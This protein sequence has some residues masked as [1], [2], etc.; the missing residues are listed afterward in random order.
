M[1]KILLLLILFATT[2]FPVFANSKI[3]VIKVYDG[4]SILAQINDNIFRIRLINI[5]CFE[6][7]AS[8]RAK[9][10]AKKYKLSLEEIVQGGN[11]AGQILKEK[12]KN[13]EVFFEFKGIDK[14]NRALG[15]LYVDNKNINS[16]MLK[17]S[18][19]KTFK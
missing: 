18:Y 12:L 15:I 7:T 10:Q 17:T 9:W 4:D 11:T 14:Y 13:K 2:S 16:E 19:C 1:K 3:N 8:S 5:D 6:G